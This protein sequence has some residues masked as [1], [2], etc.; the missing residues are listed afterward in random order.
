[1]LK[2]MIYLKHCLK[3]SLNKYSNEN[4]FSSTSGLDANI[5]LESIDAPEKLFID[6]IKCR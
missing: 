5:F 6:P 1:M 4:L 2:L 3:K